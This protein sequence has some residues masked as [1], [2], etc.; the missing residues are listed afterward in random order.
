MYY[1]NWLVYQL[2]NDVSSLGA[3]WI[4]FIDGGISERY[5]DYG[6][7]ATGLRRDYRPAS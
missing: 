6:K 1:M 3:G 4:V 5:D 2:D 7:S